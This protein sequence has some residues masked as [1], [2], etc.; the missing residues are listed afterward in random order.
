M[1]DMV[2][3]NMTGRTALTGSTQ[4]HGCCLFTFN[5]QRQMSPILCKI[6]S[7]FTDSDTGEGEETQHW[8]VGSMLPSISLI[9]LKIRPQLTNQNIVFCRGPVW[10]L[11]GST[12]IAFYTR[13][14]DTDWLYDTTKATSRDAGHHWESM[15]SGCL[16]ARRSDQ[17]F[18]RYCSRGRKIFLLTKCM[19]LFLNGDDIL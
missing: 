1:F 15:G 7:K 12:W 2:A 13:S 10:L 18:Q 6:I 14:L 4:G 5:K 9:F 3:A 19:V 8:H 11:G 16:E 17:Q